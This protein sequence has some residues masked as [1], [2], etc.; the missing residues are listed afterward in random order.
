MMGAGPGSSPHGP[1][2]ILWTRLVGKLQD[3]M[4]AHE[5]IVPDGVLHAMTT[6]EAEGWHLSVSFKPTNGN[7]L[8]LP[9]WDELKDARY[10]FIPDRFTMAMLLPPRAEWVDFHPTTMHL[11]QVPDETGQNTTEET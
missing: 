3:T 5:A 6:L 2:G 4:H 11:W 8:R 10:R 9:T 1:H 7:A